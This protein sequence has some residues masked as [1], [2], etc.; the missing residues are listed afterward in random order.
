MKK[1][2]GI[3]DSISAAWKIQYSVHSEKLQD[4]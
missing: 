3:Y 2:Y 4:G 1:I